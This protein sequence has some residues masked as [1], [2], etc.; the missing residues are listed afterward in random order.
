MTSAT[1]WNPCV[2]WLKWWDKK[3]R[4]AILDRPITETRARVSQAPEPSCYDDGETWRSGEI[5][6]ECGR[7]DG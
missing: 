6:R 3:K 5:D 4:Q 2:S 7:N 1:R